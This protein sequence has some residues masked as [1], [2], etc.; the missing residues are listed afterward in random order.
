MEPTKA[1]FILAI[2]VISVGA[3]LLNN[4]IRARHGFSVSDDWG[5][6]V[7]KE[8]PAHERRIAA[9]AQENDELRGELDR[10]RERLVTVERIVTDPSHALELEI[11]R[12]QGPAS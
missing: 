6:T 10:I 12:L 3:W 1:W 9:L 2:I 7:R 4:L 5:R 11:G 8:D